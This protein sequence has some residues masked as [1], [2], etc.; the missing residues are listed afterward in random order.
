M[1][2]GEVTCEIF[3]RHLTENLKQEQNI[4]VWNL[5]EKVCN[6]PTN[7]RVTTNRCFLVPRLDITPGREICVYIGE[8]GQGHNP[9]VAHSSRFREV[10]E[11]AQE[12]VSGL[13][14]KSTKKCFPGSKENNVSW[15]VLSSMSSAGK[16]ELI[17]GQWIFQSGGPC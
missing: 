3:L 9:G 7:V 1:S 12:A 8:E 11:R 10:R 5:E 16:R 2:M 17:V 14:H 4:H 6:G 15:K 13:E